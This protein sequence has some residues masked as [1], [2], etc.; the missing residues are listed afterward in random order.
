MR[1]WIA[2]LLR[3]KWD[4]TL[5]SLE[6]IL[7]L[8]SV[9]QVYRAD[10]DQGSFLIRL[11]QGEGAYREY[12][13][14]RFCLEQA[15][16]AGILVP[17]PFDVG[18]RDNISYMV[19]EFLDGVNGSLC[20]E[21]CEYIWE[22]LGEYAHKIH[23]IPVSG[24]GLDME[25]DG[26]FVNHF[27]PTLEDHIAYN[28]K[29]LTPDDVLMGKAYLPEQQERIRYELQHLLDIQLSAGNLPRE[30]LP[31]GLI[32][33]DL[34]LRNTIL[35]GERVYLIDFGCA[36]AGVIPYEEVISSGIPSEGLDCFWR[37]YFKDGNQFEIDQHLMKVLSLLYSYDKLRWAFDHQIE[38]I[39][40]YITN[41]K[42]KTDLLFGK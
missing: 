27:S 22:T 39:E 12:L 4:L 29:S 11:R 21:R 24:F 36:F 7:G 20:Q 38:D 17:R 31:M 2:S 40:G 3:E 6:P 25:G 41:A 18:F 33:G 23:C 16:L 15:A 34:S 13:K 30:R 8:G 26:V 37:G 5:V 19:E 1:E 10:T 32:H 9:N 28:V 42:I 14:E 35:R